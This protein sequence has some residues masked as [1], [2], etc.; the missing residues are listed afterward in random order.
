MLTS[1]KLDK[2][3]LHAVKT[4]DRAKQVTIFNKYVENSLNNNPVVKLIAQYKR[5]S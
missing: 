3:M 5:E 4:K 2:E 1:Y